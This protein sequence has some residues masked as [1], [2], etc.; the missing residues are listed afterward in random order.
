VETRKKNLRRM[1][2]GAG[3]SFAVVFPVRNPSILAWP[4]L[5]AGVACLLL[6]RWLR[7]RNSTITKIKYSIETSRNNENKNDGSNDAHAS[8]MSGAPE[9]NVIVHKSLADVGSRW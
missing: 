3:T 7:S 2:A 8:V 9:N 6:I 4:L 5:W 1:R